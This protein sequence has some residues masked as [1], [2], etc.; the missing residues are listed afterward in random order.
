[1]T[2]SPTQEIAGSGWSDWWN[3][4]SPVGKAFPAL[5]V[6]VIWS[7]YGLRGD[8]RWDPVLLWS[9]YLGLYYAGPR[10]HS[11]FYFLLPQV[12]IGLIYDFQGGVA[13]FFS[14]PVLVDGIYH[15]E[16]SL[17]GIPGE[18]GKLIPAHWW[19]GHS[20][21]LLD[22]LSGIS[23][24]VFIPVFLGV[25]A[26]FR[27]GRFSFSSEAEALVWRRRS[28]LI[29][30][31]NFALYVWAYLIWMVLPVAPPWYVELYGLGPAQLGVPP[32]A[33]GAAR[34]DALVGLPF[35]ESYYARNTNVFGALPSLHCGQTFLLFLVCLSFRKWR[36]LS[37]GF[38]GLVFF[39]S[40]Y[41]NHHYILDGL[42]G[43][44][45]AALVWL[46]FLQGERVT[47]P[48]VRLSSERDS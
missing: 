33:A 48:Q 24:L 26:C 38:F 10:F 36:G 28:R 41:L 32:E 1:M 39:A 12:L 42:L 43:M 27:F 34:F 5:A 31:S 4:V 44:A 30:W 25:A 19:Q 22:G 23:Y 29:L 11:C 15:L 16:L 8:L 18:S 2:F 14:R 3:G 20:Q 7:L 47:R 21:A 6:P 9:V 45:M 35:F 46:L 17:F 40:V 13:R 37:L